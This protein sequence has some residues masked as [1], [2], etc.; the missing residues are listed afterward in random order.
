MKKI[1]AGTLSAGKHQI[2]MDIQFPSTGIYYIYYSSENIKKT[3][4]LLVLK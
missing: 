3:S 4:N 1:K 2:R